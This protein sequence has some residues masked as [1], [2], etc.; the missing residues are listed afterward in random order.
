MNL[1]DLDPLALALLF[2]VKLNVAL[3]LTATSNTITEQRQLTFDGLVKFLRDSRRVGGAKDGP[4]FSLSRFRAPVRNGDNV[5]T[6]CG[7]VGDFDKGS[8][9]PGQISA[10]LPGL[11]HIIYTTYS[12]GAERAKYRLVVPYSEPVTAADHT[13][14][15]LY[16]SG[17]FGGNLDSNAKDPPHL[18]YLP[19]CPATTQHLAQFLV[20]EGALFDALALL[21]TLPEV[22][23][24][25]HVEGEWTT[26]P[27]EG[28]RIPQ[29]G[30]RLLA[31][32]FERDRVVD[33]VSFSD[34][35]YARVEALAH[36]W[37]PNN[38]HDKFDHSAAEASLIWRLARATASNCSQVD[39][40]IRRSE[41]AKAREQSAKPGKWGDEGEE[42]SWL[43]KEIRKACARVST[44]ETYPD[45]VGFGQG[46]KPE[47][48]S[49][50]PILKT[51]SPA[52][53]GT[54]APAPPATP[55]QV[56]AN[57][58]AGLPLP[59]AR[60]FVTQYF[61]APD[62]LRTL[63]HWQDQFYR[64]HGGAWLPVPVAEVRSLLWQFLELCHEKPKQKAVNEVLDALKAVVIVPNQMKPPVWLDGSGAD[65]SHLIVCRNGVLDPDTG[66]FSPHTPKLFTLSALSV[67]YDPQAPAPVAWLKFLASLW[68]N[69]ADSIETL[70]E[71]GGL[72]L[73]PVTKFH[74]LFLIVGPKRSGKGTILRILRLILGANHIA[75]PTLNQLSKDFGLQQLI[76]KLAALIGDARLAGPV[77]KQIAVA[78]R[79]LSISGEDCVSIPRKFLADFTAQLGVRFVLASNE[80]PNMK[81]ASGA[82]ASR[83]VLLKLTES[84]LGR[85]DLEL[86][87]RLEH[88]LPAI[89]AWFLAGRARLFA[90]R[91]FV[92][93]ASGTEELQQLEDLA[94]PVKAFVRDCCAIA[95][96][97]SV[98]K[99]E[100]FTSWRRWCNE[101]N[102]S[103]GTKETFSKDLRAAFPALVT[104]HPTI[105]GK[106][107]WVWDGIALTELGKLF[108]GAPLPHLG[109]LAL[110]PPPSP[111]PW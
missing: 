99:D 15:W 60:L 110:A 53:E 1:L 74:K 108:G 88:E 82:L 101:A 7:F 95:P 18:F 62:G 30:E 47:G 83:F 90:R 24:E 111:P 61:T 56:P 40:I 58:L 22:A 13:R 93:P 32:L 71:I 12:H 103:A 8:H 48:C 3:G 57:E 96:G 55:L 17:L 46:P 50:T 85:E 28:A 91:H 9:T 37:P 35:Y 4:W 105:A 89:L 68:P 69:E 107:T 106:R 84:F 59:A 100:L 2:D 87:G 6:L 92:Q 78:E 16:F 81:D 42:H 38:D 10:V 49:E 14:L 97:H 36:R 70:Q 65:A 34:L 44:W 76:G 21:P 102:S 43:G 25:D 52:M 41:L 98:P 63:I 67:D 104:R 27:R 77:E 72:L 20:R 45:L 75:T 109:I 5:D 94:S 86:Q 26:V 54:K 64:H 29:D 79:L 39:R 51:A 11:A 19:S 23:K 66:T 33:G 73:T 31:Q 80:V